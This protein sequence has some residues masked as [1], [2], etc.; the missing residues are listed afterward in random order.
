M[1]SSFP[2][3]T[4]STDLKQIRIFQGAPRGTTI[5][6]VR[7]DSMVD[8]TQA[9]LVRL[10]LSGPDDH[11]FQLSQD[12]L[13]VDEYPKLSRKIGE[14]YHV[15]IEAKSMENPG[16]ILAVKK[17]AIIMSEKNMFAPYFMRETYTT[18]VFRYGG[19]GENILQLEAK[20]DDD[21]RYN[22]ELTFRIL[23][24]YN[25]PIGVSEHD[26]NIFT[27]AGIRVAP[28]VVTATVI[29]TDSGSPQLTNK[30][31]VTVFIRDI[32]GN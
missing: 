32:S 4:P 29:V 16:K 21:I 31:N 30:T 2:D 10:S 14:T 12:S 19:A 25:V 22:R 1:F 15:N 18:E 9:R 20:D 27:L 11:H 28:S 23:H 17:L 8:V 5:F 7:L 6:D 13:K 26:G 24:G 3:S